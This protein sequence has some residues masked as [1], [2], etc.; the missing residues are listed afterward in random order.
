VP[1]LFPVFKYQRTTS[2]EG[3]EKQFRKSKKVQGVTEGTLYEIALSLRITQH[4][5]DKF[6]LQRGSEVKRPT[7]N[8]DIRNTSFEL[9]LLKIIFCFFFFG[10]LCQKLF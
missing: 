3:N 5:I 1:S 8:K 7:L 4:I 9:P 6:I 2:E 10:K